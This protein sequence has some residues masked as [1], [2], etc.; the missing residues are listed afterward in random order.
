MTSFGGNKKYT[1]PPFA[2]KN[3]KASQRTTTG[4]WFS[5][6]KDT[7]MRSIFTVLKQ[8]VNAKSRAEM[9]QYIL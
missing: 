1:S 8:S 7:F 2:K 4:G 3:K 5:D 6:L 9:K